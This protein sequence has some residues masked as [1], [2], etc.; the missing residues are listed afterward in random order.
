MSANPPAASIEGFHLAFL[1]VFRSRTDPR[2]FALKGGAN[3]RYF[4]G[5]VRYS[6]DVDID[7]DAKLHGAL[8]TKVDGVL[9]GGVLHRLLAAQR[10]TIDEVS[11]P[12]QTSTT[13]RWKV[14]LRLEGRA[15]PIRTKIEFNSRSD[16]LEAVVDPVPGRVVAPYGMVPPLL[17]HYAAAE[18]FDQKVRALAGRAQTQA[19]D[20]FDLDLLLRAHPVPISAVPED[21]RHSAA[22][23]ADHLEARAFDDHVLTFLEPELRDLYRDGWDAMKHRVFEALVSA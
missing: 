2:R 7:A 10:L 5:S 3:L 4:F 19:R 13:R 15:E 6:E 21:V 14:G 8:R 17:P 22:E 11:A 20:V 12:K 1:T 16:P 23:R 18:A 9:E